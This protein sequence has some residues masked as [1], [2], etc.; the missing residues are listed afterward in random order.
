MPHSGRLQ[1]EG[2]FE[3]P[4]AIV[5]VVDADVQCHCDED[6]IVPAAGHWESKFKCKCTATTMRRQHCST[7]A[8]PNHS[9][10]MSRDAHLNSFLGQADSGV[11]VQALHVDRVNPA[12][13]ACTLPADGEAGNLLEGLGIHAS[14][15]RQLCG[16]GAHVVVCLLQLWQQT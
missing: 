10:S 7:M 12:D 6:V 11:N 14:H 3:Q 16:A 8:I 5:L 9:C 4:S 13:L 15:G 1:D 2:G